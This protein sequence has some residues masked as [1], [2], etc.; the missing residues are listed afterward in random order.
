VSAHFHWFPPAW[1]SNWL[2]KF[3]DPVWRGLDWY[4]VTEARVAL[5]NGR[6][7]TLSEP[8]ALASGFENYVYA[9]SCNL[10]LG[11]IRLVIVFT[12]AALLTIGAAGQAF[13]PTGS[14]TFEVASIKPS[15]PGEAYVGIHPTPGGQRYVAAGSP[16]RDYL[17]VAYQVRPDQITGGPGWVET[18]LYDMN[19]EADRPSSIEDLHIM[20]QNLLTERFK[21]R[22]HYETKEMPAYVLTLDRGGPKNLKV[23]PNASGGDV[24]L[25]R[26]TDPLG[27]EKW[28]AHCASMNFF[29]WRLSPW[30]DRPFVNQTNLNGCF[31]FELTFTREQPAVSQGNAAQGNAPND[32]APITASGP[33]IFDALRNQLGLRLEAKRGPVA[34][35][36]IDHAER[37]GEN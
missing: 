31:D 34:T 17:Y 16:L 7:K 1:L 19:A 36:V 28:S 32:P 22:F 3:G 21:L 29:I 8:G 20:L 27:A 6:S 24:I 10:V 35:L 26:T 4:Q 15:T 33:P 2:S 9:N 37:P 25:D 23:H 13:A 11:H 12:A 30:F 18:E 5:P 14:L